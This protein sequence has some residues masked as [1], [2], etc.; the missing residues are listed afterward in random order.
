[1]DGPASS[2][3]W[4]SVLNEMMGAIEER[5]ADLSNANR[6]L[7]QK[8]RDLI[9]ARNQAATDPLTG[10]G[11]HRSFQ[12]RLRAEVAR[13]QEDGSSVGLI[14]IDLDGFKDVNDSLGHLAGDQLLRDLA[15]GSPKS[16]ATTTRSATAATSWLSCCPALSV[17]TPSQWLTG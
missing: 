1:M 15:A 14:I 4:A 11:N 3:T 9:D 5:T 12:N 8:N 17:R 2:R 10:L 13:A 16:P 7:S 6:E